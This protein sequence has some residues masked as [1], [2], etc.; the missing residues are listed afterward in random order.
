MSTYHH[1]RAAILAALPGALV[2]EQIEPGRRHRFSTNGKPLDKSGWALLF[3]DLRGGI[4]GCWRAGFT[5]GWQ[6][7][8]DRP[9]T[10]AEKAD[11]TRQI[12]A[13]KRAREAEQR[14]QWAGNAKRLTRLWAESRPITAGD[15]V[16]L[17]LCARLRLDWREL[18]PLIDGKVIR[19]HP[20]LSYLH[21]DGTVTRHPGMVAAMRSPA[22]EL[23]SVHRTFLT[24]DGRK[25]EVPQVKKLMPTAGPMDGACIR[26]GKPTAEGRIGVAEGI[27]TALSFALASHGLP[28]VAAYSAGGLASWQWPTDARH[29][30]IAA[31]NDGAGRRAGEDLHQRVIRA[32][33]SVSLLWPAT[34]GMDW[35]DV[36]AQRGAVEVRQ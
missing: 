4:F 14:Q 25:A 21:D 9:L 30:V 27:E 7:R 28:M 5:H 17:Y 31:D 34:V 33:F 3:N 2:P 18:A 16:A 24:D 22:G 11:R 8:N 10:P 15:P 20:A 32:G 12:E 13:A 6:A 1:F 23:A 19:F 26:L 29:I 36:W 35:C